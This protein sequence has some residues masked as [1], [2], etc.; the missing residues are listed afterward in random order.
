MMIIM[1]PVFAQIGETLHVWRERQEQRALLATLRT[2][3]ARCRPVLSDI[4]FEVEKRFGG[5]K[6]AASRRRLHKGAPA[7]VFSG[8]PG[9]QP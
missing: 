8:L 9:S 4:V 7:I 6:K 1:V 2:R 5:L 3:S